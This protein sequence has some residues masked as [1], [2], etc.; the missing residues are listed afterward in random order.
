MATF[1]HLKWFRILKE[2]PHL[3]RSLDLL[4]FAF[5]LPCWAHFLRSQSPEIVMGSLL[6]F[7]SLL[8]VV[9]S[10]L[11]NLSALHMQ[12]FARSINSSPHQF[13]L[14]SQFFLLFLQLLFHVFVTYID[15]ILNSSICFSNSKQHSPLQFSISPKSLEI[16]PLFIF[17]S[18][19]NMLTAFAR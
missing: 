14:R 5:L 7:R 18:L 1:P 17:A 2:G 9:M 10:Q 11:Y 4:R 16:S 6:A 19:W 8:D 3:L 13:Y 15:S 12:A